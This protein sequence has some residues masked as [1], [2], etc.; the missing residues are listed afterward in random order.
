MSESL[1]REMDRVLGQARTTAELWQTLNRL[2]LAS[3]TEPPLA[4][5]LR[6]ALKTELARR[7]D[8]DTRKIYALVEEALLTGDLRPFWAAREAYATTSPDLTARLFPHEPD[9]DEDLPRD[10][11]FPDEAYESARRLIREQI[12]AI[13][14]TTPTGSMIEAFAVLEDAIAREDPARREPLR[15]ALEL[16]RRRQARTGRNLL[17]TRLALSLSLGRSYDHFLANRVVYADL[18]ADDRRSLFTPS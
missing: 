2:G 16:E 15:Y 17:R 7:E 12:A 5:M 9:E 11:A 1:G 14:E 10:P 8:E 18:A 4:A 13:E 6:N 3:P